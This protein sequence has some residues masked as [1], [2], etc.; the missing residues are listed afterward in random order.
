MYAQI[1]E[2]GTTA[3][4]STELRRVIQTQL[5]PA[6]RA[7]PGF[8]GALNLVEGGT[9]STMTVM[10][11]E[12]EEQAAEWSTRLG[13]PLARALAAVAGLLSKAPRLSVWEVDCRL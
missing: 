3:S 4:R 12:T 7:E 8:S 11:W 6:L 10:F 2:G 13:T 1:L 5:L 9:G